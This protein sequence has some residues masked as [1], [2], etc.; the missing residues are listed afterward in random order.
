MSAQVLVA[1]TPKQV[2]ASVAKAEPLREQLEERGVFVVPL[3]VFDTS[4]QGE[5]PELQAADLK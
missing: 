3:P 5:T 4:S 2:E 1:G